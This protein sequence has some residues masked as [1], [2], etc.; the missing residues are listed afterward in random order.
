[1]RTT[2][3]ASDWR[4]TPKSYR[5]RQRHLGGSVSGVPLFQ[6]SWSTFNGRDSFTAATAMEA[7]KGIASRGLAY[8]PA[9]GLRIKDPGGV[10]LSLKALQSLAVTQPGSEQPSPEKG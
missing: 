3:G 1:M 10:G 4:R 5:G 7:F 8:P 9:P 6:V 2:A